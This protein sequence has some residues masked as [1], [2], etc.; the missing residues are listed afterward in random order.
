MYVL[1]LTKWCFIVL[2]TP[3]IPDHICFL[4]R[5][6][7]I[8]ERVAYYSYWCKCSWQKRQ[9]VCLLHMTI[10]IKIDICSSNEFNPSNDDMSQKFVCFIRTP[11]RVPVVPLLMCFNISFYVCTIL[12]FSIFFRIETTNIQCNVIHDSTLKML[13]STN[14]MFYL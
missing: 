7:L 5:N 10:F 9:H 11:E 14:C 2:K 8:Q 1:N 3:H 12:A 13:S 4:S 6:F